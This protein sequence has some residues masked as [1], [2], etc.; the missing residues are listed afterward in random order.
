L[1]TTIHKALEK[2]ISR[3]L[4]TQRILKAFSCF[5][6]KRPSSPEQELSFQFSIYSDFPTKKPPLRRP[7]DKKE[8]CY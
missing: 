3:P 6:H 8:V 1:K 2:P 5:W 7:T 4:G